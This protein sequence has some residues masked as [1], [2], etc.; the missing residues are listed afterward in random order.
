MMSEVRVLL[1]PN[2]IDPIGQGVYSTVI[3]YI[4]QT[5]F[6]DELLLQ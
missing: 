1:G 6:C 5:C 2:T 3:V 4:L